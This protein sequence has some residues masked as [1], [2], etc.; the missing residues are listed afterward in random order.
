MKT[1]PS[2]SVETLL[3][4][5]EQFEALPEERRAQDPAEKEAL[6]VALIQ[7]LISD[8]PGFAEVA[9]H[10]LT[11]SDFRSLQALRI[12]SGKIGGKAGG[13]LLAWK[14]LRKAA[15]QAAEQVVIPRSRY[16]GADVYDDFLAR[17]NLKY[18]S[19]GEKTLEL[20]RK[21]YPHIQET[22]LRGRFSEEILEPLRD[23]LREAGDTP[24]IVRSSG[25]L[26][27]SF[28]TAFAG[29]YLSVFCPNQGSAE[30]NLRDLT[31]AICRVYASV[32]RPDALTYRRKM[33]LMK[34]NERMAV[35]LQEVQG[36]T[37][38]E[39]F[40][41]PLAGIAYSF[42]PILWDARLRR[43][44]GFCRLVMGLG[45]RAVDRVA[46][47]Y[48]RLVTLSHPNLRPE[49]TPA[50]IR[51]YSQKSVDV[52]D[53]KTKTLRTVPVSTLLERDFP[54]L[55]WL[56][57]VDQGDTIMPPVS[58]G[59]RHEP[60]RMVLTFDAFL[61]RTKFVPLLKE[62]LST[63][64]R[65]YRLPVDVEFAV[66]M[67]PESSARNFTF[68]LLQ[69]RAQTG[70]RG[71]SGVRLPKEIPEENKLFV[72]TRIVPQGVVPQ[73]EY[74]CYVDPEIYMDLPDSGERKNVAT[75]IG[76][77]NEAL[78]DRTYMLIGPGRWGSINS[79]LGVPVTYADIHNTRVLVELA[80][81]QQEATPEPSYG[82][83]FFQ[84]LVEAEIY[85]LAIY[86]DQ[87]GDVFHKEWL[88]KAVNRLNK[89]LPDLSTRN[90]C[91]KLIDVP[92]E[93]EGRKLDIVMDGETAVAFLAAS[94][95][96]E[97]TRHGGR[98]RDSTG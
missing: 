76:R 10:W 21:E 66:T 22:Y 65:E 49:T 63:L 51:R 12:G 35:L 33:G 9:K 20:I 29:K 26:E 82:T 38:H 85:P 88:E 94:E 61:Q 87:P 11:A 6:V 32:N 4:R 96:N 19:R 7:I 15:P 27:D 57:S 86:P 18:R 79:L 84:D 17:N 91:V 74:I 71:A 90:E 80:V 78:E 16:V 52:I 59:V 70:I 81:E 5:L 98:K 68:H 34:E 58:L 43:E 31:A 37:Y 60:E 1:P 54:P 50:A 45:T 55:Q 92:R 83:H 14:I 8:R 36:K 69:C 24:W 44:E 39:Y 40:F 30:E 56:A 72:A 13:L 95:G 73:V 25:L 2:T 42:S 93:F 75:V 53:R 28:G 41:P 64:A 48:P 47:D 46:E 67:D 89:I 77:L 3:R 23:F 97:R 62:I